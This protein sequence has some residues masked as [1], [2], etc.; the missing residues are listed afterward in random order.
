MVTV[1]AR[2]AM[3]DYDGYSGLPVIN[4]YLCPPT[5]P[6]TAAQKRDRYCLR[7]IARKRAICCSPGLFRIDLGNLVALDAESE[8]QPLLAEDEG[9]DVVLHS[10]GR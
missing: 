1:E 3:A 10:R 6:Y 2:V 5:A 4:Y 9:I 7:S 8:H